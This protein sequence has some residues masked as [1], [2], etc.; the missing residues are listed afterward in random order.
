MASI[1]DY[2]RQLAERA[3]QGVGNVLNTAQSNIRGN[4][5]MLSNPQT[6]GTYLQGVASPLTTA[7]QRPIQNLKTNFSILT[8]PQTS[9]R[10][11]TAFQIGM[12]QPDIGQPQ[13]IQPLRQFISNVAIPQTSGIRAFRSAIP[14]I[15]QPGLLNKTSAGLQM[16]SGAGKIVAPATPLGLTANILSLTRPDLVKNDYIR[17]A[18]AGFYQGMTGENTVAQNVPNINTRLPV[19]GDVDVVKGLSSFVG[20]TKNPVN[21]KIFNLTNKILPSASL[22]FKKWLVVAGARGGIENLIMTLPDMPK[23]ISPQEKSQFLLQNFG[24]GTLMN[25]AGEGMLKVAGKVSNKSGINKLAVKIYDELNKFKKVATEEWHHNGKIVPRWKIELEKIFGVKLNP[26]NTIEEATARIKV[27]EKETLPINP[28][29]RT[30]ILEKVKGLET[31]AQQDIYEQQIL[32][33]AKL[34]K[35]SRLSSE[36]LQDISTLR[37]MARSKA[38]QEG[39]IETLY[40]KNTKLVNKVLDRMREI[41]SDYESGTNRSDEELLDMALNMPTKSEIKVVKPKE[42]EEIKVLKEKAKQVHDFVYNSEL[43]PNVK[44]GLIKNNQKVLEKAAEQ[45]YKE[46]S[47]AIFKQQIQQEK[48]SVKTAIGKITEGIRTTT[49]SPLS[50]NVEELKDISGFTGGTRDI[51]RNFKAVFVDKYN[52]AKRLFLD[53]FD[54]SKS[55]DRLNFENKWITELEKN[56]T[57]KGIK[58]GSPLSELT[59]LYGE[60]Q[61]DRSE[62]IKRAPNDWQKVI[63][64]DTWFRKAY[65]TLLEEVNR[66][67]KLIYPNSPEKLIP[68][69]KDYY[70]HFREIAQGY[71]AL[72]KIFE[73]PSGIESGLSGVSEFTK[74]KS[75]WL[76]FAQK[77]LGMK[78][79]IDAVGGF[80]DYLRA[81]G[82]ATHVDPFI[83]QF[84]NLAQEL[85]ERT[86]PGTPQAGKLNNFIEFLHDFSNDLSGKTNPLDRA[87]QKWIPGGR[88]TFRVL[89]WIN[90]R[91]KANTILGKL[92]VSVAQ[93]FNV[94]QGIASAGL[95]NAAKGLG[96]S[97]ASMFAKNYPME[98]SGFIRERYTRLYDKFDTSLLDNTKKFA[99]W[100]SGVLDE[101]GTKYIWNSHYEQA[102]QKN[103]TNPIKYADDMTR[104]LVAG[105]GIGEVP[106][107]QKARLFQLIA[108]FQLEVGNLWWVMKDMVDEKAFG[109]IAT[110]F[111]ANYLFNRTAEK[112]RGSDVTIDPIQATI[113]A[114]QAFSEEEDKKKGAL[115]AGGRL[116]GEVISNIPGGQTIASGWLPLSDQQRKEFFGKGDP[117][118]FGSGLLSTKGLQ[119]PLYKIL[120]PF[121]G[122]QLKTTIEGIGAVNRGYSETQGGKIQ[123][124]IEKTPSTY[125]K[126]ATFGKSS[127]PEAQEF[128]RTKQTPL[129][130]KQ[131]ASYKLYMQMKSISPE[132]RK[133]LLQE[134][135]QKKEITENDIRNIIQLKQSESKELP[136]DE[137][138]L[139]IRGSETKAKYV[140][141]LLQGK[142]REEK[143]E[144]LRSYMEKGL[145]DESVL[146]VIIKMKK[147]GDK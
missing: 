84:R 100:I 115:K 83:P 14:Q 122:A 47:N 49:G 39:D 25:I 31:K 124:P 70:R 75:K 34:S 119:D 45:E 140:N 66:I 117:A 129:G 86:A 89:D 114:V 81:A 13:A 102:L 80:L 138:L 133:Q 63:E 43:D 27:P 69:R 132:Q 118:R 44:S 23:D 97:L 40:K 1:F 137:V 111:I 105:R 28:K 104:N 144:I 58:K 3:R 52:E 46:W 21:E 17:R 62:L 77:R 146:K 130:D 136:N 131:T 121:G 139:S 147:G 29:P 67:R 35:I 48:T 90:S 127:L 76:S 71:E 108:P 61:I 59:Q 94:P 37:K 20:F 22:P 91:V 24:T 26:P 99:G 126:G 41:T 82:Y 51:Y 106:L 79:E 16:L 78:S 19:F 10:A 145:I 60:G 93:I 141:K 113:E 15:Q 8:N 42:F 128:Y 38:G 12:Q 9:P 116:A 36:D 30:A 72:I 142:T 96:R 87:A 120:P 32:N 125:I 4:I 50:K 85:A 54:K 107:A 103:I 135:L 143:K 2:A 55:I 88:K 11:R 123:Y 68:K 56:I 7:V 109:K 112:I 95:P 33:E 18:G 73:N 57:N 5:Q 101:V 53:P 110:L 74:P 92:S 98:Q 6:R 64:A 65:D 134:K